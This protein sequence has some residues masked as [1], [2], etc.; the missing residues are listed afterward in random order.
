[1][2]NRIKL[3]LFKNRDRQTDNHPHLKNGKPVDVP[4]SCGKVNRHWL[5]GFINS[6]NEQTQA[7]IGRML[8]KL[9]AENG[10]YPI[11][12]ISLTPAEPQA[13]AASNA[14]YED[15]SDPF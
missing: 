15:E 4:C 1:M 12:N 9:E 8:D 6:N 5:A 10:N 11:L 2:T 14:G 3:T 13:P 7:S